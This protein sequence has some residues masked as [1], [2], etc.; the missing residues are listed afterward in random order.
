MN[1]LYTARIIKETADR[2]CFYLIRQTCK[3]FSAMRAPPIR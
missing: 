2:S 1:R 3:N